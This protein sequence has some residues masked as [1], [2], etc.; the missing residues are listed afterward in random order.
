MNSFRATFRNR[1][2][3]L[4]IV[5]VQS[6]DQTL[7]NVQVAR[8]AGAD[9]VFLLSPGEISDDDVLTIYKDVV[10]AVPNYWVGVN[11]LSL[12]VEEVVRQ[13]GE[14]LSGLWTDDA[15]IDETHEEQPVAIKLRDTLASLGWKGLYFGGVAFKYQRPVSDVAK[16]ARLASAYMDVVTTS[17]PGTG[18]AASPGKVRRMKEAIGEHPMALASGV[19]LENVTDYLPW[20]DGVIVSTGISETLTDLDP[21]RVRDLVR[22]VRAWR[23]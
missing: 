23:E 15:L 6:R 10:E 2:V 14:R 21:C 1:H 4:P 3:V 7:R 17:G 22:I 18:Q 9:G 19:T 16:A 5:H 11:C 20:V 8:N 12:S 13:A